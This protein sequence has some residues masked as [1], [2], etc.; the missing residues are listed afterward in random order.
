MDQG[1]SKLQSLTIDCCPSSIPPVKLA[2]VV[3]GLRKAGYRQEALEKKHRVAL[4]AP[5]FE[6]S[7]LEMMDIPGLRWF[8]K[9]SFVKN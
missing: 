4:M 3:A 6:G 1:R 5:L 8:S 2:R 9:R 7:K